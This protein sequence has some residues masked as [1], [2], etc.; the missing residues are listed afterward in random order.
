MPS[1]NRVL[2]DARTSKEAAEARKLIGG[3]LNSASLTWSTILE[4]LKKTTCLKIIL[5]GIMTPDDALLAVE[6]SVD[7]IVVS[8]RGG[9]QL[10]G[11]PST[12]EAL[13]NIAAVVRGRIPVV[14][15]GGIRQGSDVFKAI[16]LG[17]DFVLIGR[18]VLWGLSWNGQRGVETV[19]NILERELSRTMALA[20]AS[21]VQE[22]C[23]D[24]LGVASQTF[25]VCKL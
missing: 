17:A 6:H 14:L 20:G 3:S 21:N 23:S 2:L 5:K 16:G 19:I 12:L 22:I 10:D 8:N 13:P 1:G 4:F 11:I 25:G 7:A 24:L 9:R 15:D 18:P